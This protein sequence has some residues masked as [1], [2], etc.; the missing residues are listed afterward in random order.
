MK[1]IIQS[2]GLDPEKFSVQRIPSG[3][4]HAT[5][6]LVGKPS[7]ILQRVNKDV[8]TQ[9]HI[10]ASNLRLA[11]DYLKKKHPEYL[12]LSALPTI[13]GKEMSFDAEGYPWRLFLFID[14]S[15]TIDKVENEEE[16][17]HAAAE[18]ARLSSH[19]D[20]VDIGLFKPTINRFH[21]LSWRYEQF[22]GAV[23][24]STGER[25]KKASSLVET[26]KKY[27]HLVDRYNELIQQ[28]S[29]HLRIT[30]N[31]AK[32]NNILLDATTRQAVCVID[33]D[34]LMPGY[35]IYDVGDMIRTF[36]S[37]AGEEE[38][39]LSKVVFRKSIYD[40]LVAGYLSQMGGRLTEIEK[41]L[42]PFAGMMMT[43]IMALRMLAD[44]LNG[45]VYYQITYPEQNYVRAANQLKLLEVF[46]TSL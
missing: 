44:F 24:T 34:T 6:K 15:I 40:G 39:D 16:A 14:N 27:K 26:C 13:N 33:L 22:E 35:F 28:G 12:F 18:F 46:S 9:P 2:F 45:D 42:F 32:I 36:V 25:L 11:A 29:L 5:Y 38:K 10:I 20:G 19:L 41:T 7:Y 43:Y 21:D 1:E 8:F 3:Y 23:E 37:P 30:H 17:Y 31:D 4:I